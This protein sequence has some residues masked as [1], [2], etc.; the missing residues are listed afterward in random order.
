MFTSGLRG[1]GMAQPPQVMVPVPQ[2]GGVVTQ[3]PTAETQLA[4]AAYQYV[5][6]YTQFLQPNNTPEYQDPITFT[7]NLIDYAKTLCYGSWAPYTCVGF[8]AVSKGT[9][10]ANQVFDALKGIT[11]S[12][13]GKSVYDT[14]LA[15]PVAITPTYTPP[16]LPAPYNPAY[17][18]GS[19][20]LP[21]PP[22]TLNNVAPVPVSVTPLPG[23]SV[24]NPPSVNQTP[25][26]QQQIVN[27]MALPDMS[28]ATSW[29][30][31]NWKVVALGVAAVVVLPSL[32][33][34]KR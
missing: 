2:P 4:N 30:Q 29:L 31:A 6:D 1:L 7:A 32:L 8:D 19:N 11:L 10:Y 21:P 23:T 14:W 33:G 9:Q 16:I 15:R 5:A 12:S 17:V 22:N 25:V 28:S 24:L 3:M 20:Q 13:T 34:G 26:T 18:P 27:G